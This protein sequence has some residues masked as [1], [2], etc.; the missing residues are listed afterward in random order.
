MILE[1]KCFINVARSFRYKGIIATWNYRK[2]TR[3]QDPLDAGGIYVEV[4]FPSFPAAFAIWVS[5]FRYSK[6]YSALRHSLVFVTCNLR[7]ISQGWNLP[8][9]APWWA[10]QLLTLSTPVDWVGASTIDSR[11]SQLFS[12]ARQIVSFEFLD[13]NGVFFGRYR[14]YAT[15][16]SNGEWGHQWMLYDSVTTQHSQIIIGRTML[17]NVYLTVKGFKSNDPGTLESCQCGLQRTFIP[18]KCL[19]QG[20]L[21]LYQYMPTY[22]NTEW[23]NLNRVENRLRSPVTIWVIIASTSL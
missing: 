19:L 10:T 2:G 7:V 14:L 9:H 22:A 23:R 6:R 17:S 21:A 12:R 15:I 5:F 8:A 4:P 3:W 18:H 1:S 16:C 13:L 20:G 11:R